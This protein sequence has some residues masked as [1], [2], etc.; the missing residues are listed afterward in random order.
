VDD[1]VLKVEL[2]GANAGTASGLDISAGS[3]TVRGL[4]VGGFSGAPLTDD[5]QDN[6][7][8]LE[9]SGGNIIEGNFLGTDPTGTVAHANGGAGIFVA[10]P[11]NL[12][13]GARPADRNLISRRPTA[14]APRCPA[15]I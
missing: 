14:S 4:V 9:G 3:S 11:N 1:A 8:L 7:I 5:K 10:S 13:G 6:G 2:S 12:I 15:P